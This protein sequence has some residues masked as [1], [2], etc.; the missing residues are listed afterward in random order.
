MV[1]RR[2]G[3]RVQVWSCV[4]LYLFSPPTFASLWTDRPVTPRDTAAPAEKPVASRE[5]PC[6]LAR[7]TG[8]AEA[9]PPS[10]GH[11]RDERLSRRPETPAGGGAF[12]AAAEI[13]DITRQAIRHDVDPS[14]WGSR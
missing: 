7:P 4:Y 6:R 5:P 14:L 3:V 11:S 9:S 13:S 12:D 10:R 2:D 1:R 8:T